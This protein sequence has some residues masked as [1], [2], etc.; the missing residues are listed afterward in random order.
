MGR[1]AGDGVDLVEDD[2]ALRRQKE[3]D[4]GKAAAAEDLIDPPGG[5]LHRGSLFRRNAGGD[6]DFGCRQ[7]V[8]L[9]KTEEVALQLDLIGDAGQRRIAAEDGAADFKAG[10]LRLQHDMVVI[11]KRVV[12]RG[13]QVAG[14]W[15]ATVARS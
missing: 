5:L 3:I 8:F 14:A 13:E 7:V 9:L 10:D 12:D 1:E 4:P 15:A 2:T 11:I 6:M